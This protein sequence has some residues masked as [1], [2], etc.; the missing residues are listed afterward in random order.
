MKLKL[1]KYLKVTNEQGD[2]LEE[3][4]LLHRLQSSGM[5]SRLVRQSP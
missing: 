2:P 4:K 5:N 1:H 3:G